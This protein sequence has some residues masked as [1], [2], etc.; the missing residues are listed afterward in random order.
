MTFV[1]TVSGMLGGKI[2][3]EEIATETK[4][5]ST[6]VVTPNTADTLSTSA[7]D[8]TSVYSSV[9]LDKEN[10]SGIDITTLNAM[11]SGED[12]TTV[13]ARE[14]KARFKANAKRWENTPEGKEIIAQYVAALQKVGEE[15]QIKKEDIAYIKALSDFSHEVAMLDGTGYVMDRDDFK[16]IKPDSLQNDCAETAKDWLTPANIAGHYCNHAVKGNMLNKG[17]MLYTKNIN[18]ACDMEGPLSNDPNFVKFEVKEGESCY[19]PNGVT[20]LYRKSSA[21][22]FGHIST[23][24]SDS[25][26]L[27]DSTM[28]KDGV[29]IPTKDSSDKLR[30]VIDENNYTGAVCFFTAHSEA[31]FTTCVAAWATKYKEDN[32]P[33]VVPKDAP[34]SDFV[35]NLTPRKIFETAIACKEKYFEKYTVAINNMPTDHEVKDG[36]IYGQPYKTDLIAK[37]ARRASTKYRSS[38][39]SSRARSSTITRT[40]SRL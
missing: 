31:S 19:V 22:P 26:A 13:A 5:D 30:N 4:T 10:I 17:L 37:N 38:S 32:R 3:A 2:S 7:A 14:L 33:L 23:A 1:I 25:I 18:P 28:L 35:S 29:D 9:I 24:V 40:H 8:S 16:D 6:E 34:V 27:N 36:Y 12:T 20:K 15:P 11:Y 21:H 39:N